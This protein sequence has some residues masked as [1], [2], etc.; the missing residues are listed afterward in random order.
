MDEQMQDD[1]L[2]PTY[3]FCADTWC[4]LKDL[5]EAKDNREVGGS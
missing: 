5:L 1:Q 4:S 3:K 2:E